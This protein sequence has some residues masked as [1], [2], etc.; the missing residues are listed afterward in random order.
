M[1][2]DSVGGDEVSLIDGEPDAV[3]VG[4][5]EGGVRGVACVGLVEELPEGAP[6]GSGGRRRAPL[7]FAPA[8]RMGGTASGYG[9]VGH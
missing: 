8:A 3:A 5:A 4:D 1:G 6:S 7:R 2:A 9:G